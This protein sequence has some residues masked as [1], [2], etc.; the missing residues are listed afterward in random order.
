MYFIYHYYDLINVH[1]INLKTK[2]KNYKNRQI[3][4]SS[5]TY[6]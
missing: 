4:C 6:S 3:L 1:T 2:K 5:L